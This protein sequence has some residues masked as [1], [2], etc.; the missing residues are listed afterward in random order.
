MMRLT[1]SL[2]SCIVLLV[3]HPQLEVHCI[4]GLYA[5][6]YKEKG[7]CTAVIP[8]TSGTD[9]KTPKVTPVAKHK[10]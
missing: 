10:S 5:N 2:R 1:M 9:P 4:F 8:I 7:Y 6:A 3:V